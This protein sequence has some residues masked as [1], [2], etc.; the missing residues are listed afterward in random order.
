MY[1]KGELPEDWDGL[2]FLT[3]KRTKPD[4]IGNLFKIKS[5]DITFD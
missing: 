4:F 1:E 3:N 5:F 2:L